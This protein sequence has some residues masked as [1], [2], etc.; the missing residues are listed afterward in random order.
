LAAN[1]DPSTGRR[2]TSAVLALACAR[3]FVA[4]VSTSRSLG[5]ALVRPL[6]PCLRQPF[7]ACSESCNAARRRSCDKPAATLSV[8]RPR[9][10]GASRYLAPHGCAHH[11]SASGNGLLACRRDH[12]PDPSSAHCPKYPGSVLR[13]WRGDGYWVVG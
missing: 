10:A 8:A 5:R 12:A 7:R 11:L 13:L 2:L 4:G 9:W 6:C 3:D 1:V